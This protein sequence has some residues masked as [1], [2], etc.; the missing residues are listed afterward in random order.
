M[1]IDGILKITSE[2]FSGS[3]GQMFFAIDSRSVGANVTSSQNL[4]IA[5]HFRMEHQ[6][7]A[8]W[9]SW[10]FCMSNRRTI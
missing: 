10:T 1:F 4:S 7:H 3:S 2:F 6:G 8:S 5:V 9:S